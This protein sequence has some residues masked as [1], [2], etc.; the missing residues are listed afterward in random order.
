VNFTQVSAG[1][2]HTCAILSNGS[3]ICWGANGIH[4]HQTDVPT[5]DSDVNFT[6]ISAG[7]LHTCAVLSNG[8]AICW[9]SNDNDQTNVPTLDSDVNFTQV[10]AGRYHT[11]AILSNDSTIC[12]GYNGYHQTEVPDIDVIFT[13]VSAGGF[14]TCAVLSDGN[15]I[16]WGAYDSVN[17]FGQSDIPHDFTTDTAFILAPFIDQTLTLNPPCLL[18]NLHLKLNNFTNPSNCQT[19][20]STV[21]LNRLN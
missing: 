17:Y 6:Q 20:T 8:S 7:L 2:Y 14:H 12:W 16:C 11:C 19:Y 18:T 1:G 21:T 9:G 4:F 13:Q 5:L 3:A 15:T 10:S